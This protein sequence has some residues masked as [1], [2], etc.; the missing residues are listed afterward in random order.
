MIRKTFVFASI[1]MLCISHLYFNHYANNNCYDYIIEKMSKPQYWNASQAVR[2]STAEL[3]KEAKKS[4][5]D[6]TGWY[7]VEDEDVIFA[8]GYQGQLRLNFSKYQAET[9]LAEEFTSTTALTYYRYDFK[10][11]NIDLIDLESNLIIKK[12]DHDFKNQ[13]LSVDRFNVYDEI[14]R[15]IDDYIEHFDMIGCPLNGLNHNEL[16]QYKKRKL[17][18]K[19]IAET[20]ETLVWENLHLA[21]NNS[22]QYPQIDSFDE[23]KTFNIDNYSKE[24]LLYENNKVYYYNPIFVLIKEDEK[25]NDQTY[26]EQLMVYPNQIVNFFEYYVDELCIKMLGDQNCIFQIKKE[27]DKQ[28]EKAITFN[29]SIE[30]MTSDDFDINTALLLYYY[31]NDIRIASLIINDF[32]N[33]MIYNLYNYL[34]EVLLYHGHDANH[35]LSNINYFLL[36]HNLYWQRLLGLR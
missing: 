17:N 26:Y 9:R 33:D 13:D 28:I 22:K 2:Y 27:E 7:L 25:N 14:K 23:L 32:N 12:F 18:T 35:D 4:L 30:H 24:Y 8:R 20:S 3:A 21:Y 11:N 34:N 6:A 29:E 36:Y 1:L 5:I 10:Q 31:P 19:V 16:K 15:N